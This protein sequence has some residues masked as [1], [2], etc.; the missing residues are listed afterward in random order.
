[1][2]S[3]HLQKTEKS[4]LLDAHAARKQWDATRGS[5]ALGVVCRYY[6]KLAKKMTGA[7]LPDGSEDG[8][9]MLWIGSA[10]LG[11][12]VKGGNSNHSFRLAAEQFER[13][14]QRAEVGFP[15]DGFLYFLFSYTTFEARRGRPG[16]ERRCLIRHLA[17]KG[18]GNRFL[19]QRTRHLW[20]VPIGFI[21]WLHK[22]NGHRYTTL[23][24]AQGIRVGRRTLDTALHDTR[25]LSQLGWNVRHGHADLL[26]PYHRTR[27]ASFS[28]TQV[29]CPNLPAVPL[30]GVTWD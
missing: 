9:L 6:E 4:L 23:P 28:V 25:V 16:Y 24:T 13:H 7:A 27:R 3:S 1:V 26:P 14:K 5:E 2:Q 21:E 8:D 11:I 29:V 19:T 10:A 18:S 17:G 12:E 30:R 15:Y 22:Q 20:V